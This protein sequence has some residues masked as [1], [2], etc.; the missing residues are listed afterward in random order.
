M[1]GGRAAPEGVPGVEVPDP[2]LVEQAKRRSFTAEYKARILAEADACTRPGEVGELLRR[3]G[4]YT[5]HLTYWRKQRKDGA[6]KELGKPRGRKPADKRDARIAALTRRAERAEAEL[7]KARRVIEIQGKRLSAAGRDARIGQRGEEHRAMIAA[8][9]EELTPIIG[10]RPACRAVGASVA[11]I[12]RRR[13]P[14]EPRTPKPRPTPA[15][16][17]T[18]PERQHVLDVLHCERFVDVSPEETWATLLDEGTYLCSA[19][20]MYRILAAHHG[21]VR[22]RRNQL[23]HPPYAKP[24]LLAERPNELWSWDISKLKGPAKWTWF[25]LYV[26]LD[27]FSRYIVGWAVQYRETAQLAKALI[28]QAAEQQQITPKV[29]TLHADRGGPMRAKPV[30]FLLADLGVTK[31]HSRPY[32]SSDNPYSESNFKTLKYRPEFPD[33][34]DSIEQAREHCR[35]FVHWCNH[36]HRHSGIGLMTPAAV[37]YGHAEQLH[38]A[39]AH[40]LDAAYARN[41]ERFVR[42]PPA[43]PE[44]PTAAWINKPADTKEIAH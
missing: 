28:E 31:T 43:P 30:A 32:T 25:Y 17:L 11:T 26:I 37:H 13:R 33:R 40:V 21:G 22:E 8:T 39:R 38:T 18:D 41:P 4:L 6:L 9:V 10:T 42:K 35:A 19:R 2:E 16:A 1:A 12:Y 29:L 24:E 3:E 23:T 36:Q 27:V 5:S 7:Q 20:T 15:R 44:L 14:P 34:F